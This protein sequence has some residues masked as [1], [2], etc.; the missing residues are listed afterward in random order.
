MTGQS[1][2]SSVSSP[3]LT[4]L[5]TG[6]SSGIGHALAE[7][8][9]VHGHRVVLAARSTAAMDMLAAR[10]PLTARVVVLDVTSSAQRSAA[11]QHAIQQFGAIDVL[12]NNAAVDFIGAI[13]EQR[14]ADCRAQFEVNLFSA[15]DMIRLVLPGM[16]SRRAGTLVNVSSMNGIASL[17]GN[18]FY[19]A[20]KFAMEGVTE[21]LRVE[22]ESLGIR[23]FTVQPGSVRTGIEARTH[24]SGSAIADY[25]ATSGRFRGQVATVTPD[26]FPGDPARVAAA[27]YNETVSSTGRRWLV[28]GSDALRRIRAKLAALQQD[29]DAAALTA[30]QTDYPG[31]GS[32]VL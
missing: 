14:D 26:M 11:V 15:V 32:A 20:T 9:L 4:W 3:P 31:A 6:A 13:E 22:L 29:L 8:A 7:H 18:G 24:A 16:R 30:P 17:P 23:A 10:F 27:I 21:A 12:V 19:S 28:L 25:A 2:S 1:R 5:I